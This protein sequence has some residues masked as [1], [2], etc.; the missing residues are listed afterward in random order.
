[1]LW[2]F[3]LSLCMNSCLDCSGQETRTKNSLILFQNQ[4][5]A[6][7]ERCHALS[8]ENHMLASQLEELR[9]LVYAQQK[10]KDTKSVEEQRKEL[11]EIKKDFYK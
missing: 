9:V 8:N 11:R 6:V 7:N 3:V 2:F 1:M 10:P 4:I 5:N